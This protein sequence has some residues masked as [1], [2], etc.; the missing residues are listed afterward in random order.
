M[1]FSCYLLSSVLG[2]LL[3]EHRKVYL[4][5]PVVSGI[6]DMECLSISRALEFFSVFLFFMI[7]L[8][9]YTYMYKILFLYDYTLYKHF[10]YIEIYIFQIPLSSQTYNPWVFIFLITP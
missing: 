1:G 9:M 5:Q 2:I 3:H 7:T 6:K 8:C 4:K 10:I